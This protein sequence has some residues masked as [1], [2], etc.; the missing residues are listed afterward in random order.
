MVEAD[1]G[2]KVS[3]EI[4]DGVGKIDTILEGENL[5]I[6]VKLRSTSNLCEQYSSHAIFTTNQFHKF[7][8]QE[9]VLIKDEVKKA[10]LYTKYN[11]A[12]IFDIWDKVY[13]KYP[14][15]SEKIKNNW[16]T[17]YSNCVVNIDAFSTIIKAYT[18]NK[19][20]KLGR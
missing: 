18:F 19:T 7:E 2:T 14:I 10:I 5:T 11:N 4:V 3:V 12:D 16:D 17:I 13:H 8:E 9:D 6:N 1:D 20:L 15:K